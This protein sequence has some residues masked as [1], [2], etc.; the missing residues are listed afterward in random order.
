MHSWKIIARACCPLPGANSAPYLRVPKGP[1]DRMGQ[2]SWLRDRDTGLRSQGRDL[3]GVRLTALADLVLS[4]A[5]PYLALD[6]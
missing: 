6:S 5:R 4:S 1:S 3:Q 2:K